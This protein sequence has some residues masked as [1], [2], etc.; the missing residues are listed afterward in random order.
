LIS[1]DRHLVEACADRL[2]LVEAGD[3]KRFDGDLEDYKRHLLDLRAG[4]RASRKG[5]RQQD[6]RKTARQ[7]A[8]EA[9]KK[10]APHRRAVEQA[11]KQLEKLLSDKEWL[12]AKLAD[13][14]LYGPGNETKVAELSK[15]A[16]QL[17]AD[18][19]TAELS[20]MEAEERYA[21]AQEAVNTEGT[22]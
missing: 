13:P 4:E 1:H 9:R 21:S 15:K 2:W 22:A 18:I 5:P 16:S 17:S 8:A 3:V 6:T 7:N 10:L 14:A 20:W 11:E 19:E 12:D